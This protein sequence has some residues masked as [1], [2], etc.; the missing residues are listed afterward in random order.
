M[1]DRM[2]ILLDEEHIHRAIEL[3]LDRAN[4]DSMQNEPISHEGSLA[5]ALLRQIGK[6]VQDLY[7]K[8]LRALRE[9]SPRQAE[10]EA[11][12]LLERFYQGVSGGGYEAA[13]VDAL[14][15]G[16]ERTAYLR[17]FLLDTVKQEER[18]KHVRWVVQWSVGPLDWEGKRVIMAIL[19]ERLHEVLP[20]DLAKASPERVAD[21]LP[22]LLLNYAAARAEVRNMLL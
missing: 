15:L 14:S 12:R 5:T 8:R 17:T 16:E 1:L 11:V 22:E 6:Y 7:A 3:P 10:A 2:L 13:F 4:R 20:P 9:L 21:Y 18:R 19:L